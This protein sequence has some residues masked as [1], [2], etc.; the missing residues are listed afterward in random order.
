M[1]DATMTIEA[2]DG[3]ITIVLNAKE[4]AGQL[5]RLVIDKYEEIK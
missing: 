3:K 1:T 5:I 4:H 2:V